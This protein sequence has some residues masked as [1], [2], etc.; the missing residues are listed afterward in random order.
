MIID[1]FQKTTVWS[2]LNESHVEQKLVKVC[3]TWNWNEVL[4]YPEQED[5]A[6]PP[7]GP[8]T[9]M[10]EYDF[11]KRII[12]AWFKPTHKSIRALVLS[13]TYPH[14]SPVQL[15]KQYRLFLYMSNYLFIFLLDRFYR[16][17]RNDIMIEDLGAGMGV[18]FAYLQV[19]G[20]S[21]FHAVD[22]WSQIPQLALEE[23]AR[24]F[25]FKVKVNDHEVTPVAVNNCG[26]N[27]CDY[28]EKTS[29]DQG[30]P[31]EPVRSEL[32]ERS[33]KPELICFYTN[34]DLEG[35]AAKTYSNKGYVYLCRDL[36]D[37]A[38]AYCR[39]DKYE[40][41]SSKLLP[42]MTQQPCYV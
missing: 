14:A 6:R 10:T 41:F 40:E 31:A 20:F 37:L 13:R 15:K 30:H 5:P 16:E 21:Q 11:S 34:R 23:L 38:V 12:S 35:Q 28:K 25:N 32:L 27:A 33:K 36:D 18:M 22:D 1:L 29:E 4:V 9:K 2:K 24:E 26:V 7:K 8:Y 39:R 3:D 42:H 17:T 19:L